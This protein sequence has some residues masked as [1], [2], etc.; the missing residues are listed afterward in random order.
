MISSDS[1][2]SAKAISEKMSEKVSEKN[3]VDERTIQRDLAKIKE[4][5]ILRRIGGRKNGEWE[6]GIDIYER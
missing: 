3:S 2:I 5:G 1:S 6:I 4:L